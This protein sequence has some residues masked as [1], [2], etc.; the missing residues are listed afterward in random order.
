MEALLSGLIGKKI[1]VNCGSNVAYR[2]EAISVEGGV[3]RLTN[4]ENQDVYIAI[5]KVAAVSECRDFG[6]RPGFIV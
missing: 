2:G 4:E 1:D 6:S 5:D 3:L